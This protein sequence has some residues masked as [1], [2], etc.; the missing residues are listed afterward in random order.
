MFGL[1]SSTNSKLGCRQTFLG[2]NMI[3]YC[4][5]DLE[6]RANVIK[7]LFLLTPFPMMYPGMFGPNPP[8]GLSE[9]GLSSVLQSNSCVDLENI[10]SMSPNSNQVFL[11]IAVMQSNTFGL[12]LFMC[13]RDMEQT[14]I[15]D[16]VSCGL[17]NTVK[18]TEV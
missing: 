10:R 18:V 13:S 14:N 17:E 16:S 2:Q 4:I 5:R 7:T 3:F 11:P 6:N 1:N 9:C 12:N 15:R 8:F